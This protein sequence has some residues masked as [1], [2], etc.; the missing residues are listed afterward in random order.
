MWEE[1]VVMRYLTALAVNKIQFSQVRIPWW[2]L[3][4]TV[5]NITVKS[6]ARNLS[7]PVATIF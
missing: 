6:T 3:I 2:A 4:H 1:E 5:I 7:S